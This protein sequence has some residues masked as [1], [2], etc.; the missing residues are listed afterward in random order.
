MLWCGLMAWKRRS[1]AM[2]LLVVAFAFQFLPWTRIERATFHYHYLTAVIFAMVA[3]SYVVALVT[4]FIGA[5][6][7][8]VYARTT[9]D[10]DFPERGVGQSRFGQ[11]SDVLEGESSGGQSRGGSR[12]SSSPP[13]TSRGRRRP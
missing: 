8:S 9:G 7:Q 10:D 5:V 6:I 11:D 13:E 3:V 2:V 12:S 4:Q 1:L